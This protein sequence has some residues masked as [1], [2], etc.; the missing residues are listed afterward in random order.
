[1]GKYYYV[2][3][4]KN[5]KVEQKLRIKGIDNLSIEV[6]Q[7]RI[8]QGYR[9][10]VFNFAIFLV[11]LL[12]KK[13]SSIYFA[14]P[15]KSPILPKVLFSFIS[16]FFFIVT[17]SYFYIVIRDTNSF[18]DMDVVLKV[19]LYIL[20]AIGI[21]VPIPSIITNIRG[22]KDV[23]ESIFEYLKMQINS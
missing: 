13:N 18:Q 4:D 8:N 11:F 19:I 12:W 6:I 23:T 9:F 16:M 3:K 15:D 14:E 21:I 5:G 2:E 7:G 1:M 10:V 22:G 17:G 20:L